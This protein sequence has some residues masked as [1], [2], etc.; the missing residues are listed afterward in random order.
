MMIILKHP[1]D[2]KKIIKIKKKSKNGFTRRQ[3]FDIIIL[4][5]NSVYS[6]ADDSNE[7]NEWNVTDYIEINN[8]I[9]CNFEYDK[10]KKILNCY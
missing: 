3:I 6:D 8:P 7:Y 2:D 4:E 1:T 10:K 9:I 5:Y